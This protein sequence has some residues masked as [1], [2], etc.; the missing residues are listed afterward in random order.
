MGVAIHLA[1]NGVSPVRWRLDPR[2]TS[3]LN[4][5]GSGVGSASGF[6]PNLQIGQLGLEFFEC[7]LLKFRI[8]ARG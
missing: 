8:G 7:S 3:F 5:S 2:Q 6:Y 1:A 4:R